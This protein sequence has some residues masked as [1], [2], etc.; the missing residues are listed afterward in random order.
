MLSHR[1]KISLKVF[2]IG[3]FL[4]ISCDNFEIDCGSVAILLK[5][6]HLTK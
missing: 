2:V 5:V 1:T 3:Q 6:R 4:K